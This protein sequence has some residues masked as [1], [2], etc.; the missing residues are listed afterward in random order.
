MSR[1]ELV[2]ISCPV[3]C[4]LTVDVE[5]TGL[6]VSGN[7]CRLGAIYG[8]KE[9]TDPRRILTTSLKVFNEEGTTFQM[10][11]VKTASDV[12]K[13]QMFECLATIKAVHLVGD[14]SVGQVVAEVCG[15]DVVATRAVK[16]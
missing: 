10:L 14:I 16:F 2:C 13:N 1:H 6:E 5:A 12:P 4:S 8:A 3:G 11:S 9:V 7:Q 15:V